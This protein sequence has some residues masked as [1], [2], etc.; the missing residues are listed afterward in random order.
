MKGALLGRVSLDMQ[1]SP[2]VP[3]WPRAMAAARVDCR[4]RA[5]GNWLAAVWVATELVVPPSLSPTRCRVMRRVCR[6]MRRV[7]SEE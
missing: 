2:Y 4:R 7:Q 1:R 5:A 3:E 6:V